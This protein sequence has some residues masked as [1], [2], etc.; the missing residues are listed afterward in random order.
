MAN[1]INRIG[2]KTGLPVMLAVSPQ[3]FLRRHELKESI[4][5]VLYNKINSIP[6]N[7]AL[8]WPDFQ[9]AFDVATGRSLNDYIGEAQNI[10]EELE[11]QQF[12]RFEQRPNKMI[13]IV[14]GVNFDK[15]SQI[16]NPNQMNNQTNIGSINANNLQVG[17]Q[18]QMT[19]NVDPAQVISALSALISKRPEDAKSIV[20]K[21]GGYVK[22]GATIAEV[23]AKFVSLMG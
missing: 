21:L 14:K 9:V 4:K 6:D 2:H 1:S 5:K 20:D 7:K 13:R 15:W 12:V 22:S 19:V 11:S 17:N 23:L 16:M 18:N 3:N 10:A 8:L